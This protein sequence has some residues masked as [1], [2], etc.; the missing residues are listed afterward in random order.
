MPKFVRARPRYSVP[1]R[2]RE[3]NACGRFLMP[4]TVFGVTVKD[5]GIGGL[6][7]VSVR[8]LGA[9]HTTVSYDG[10]ALTDVQSGQ[11]DIGRFRWKMW[12]WFHSAAVK[13]ITSF[14]RPRLCVGIGVEHPDTLA[15]NFGITGKWMAKSRWKAVHSGLINP[16]SP[17]TGKF[18][19]RLS[20][21]QRW[22]GLLPTGISQVQLR[23]RGEKDKPSME[24]RRN[25]DVNNLRLEAALYAEFSDKS[26]GY[27]KLILPVG[28]RIAGRDHLLQL[29]QLFHAAHLGQHVF[30]AGSLPAQFRGNGKFRQTRNTT[31]D[32]CATLIPLFW[33]RMENWNIYVHV[34]NEI[35]GSVSTLFRAFEIFFS[36]SSDISGNTLDAAGSGFASPS[37]LSWSR[38]LPENMYPTGATPRV[39]FTLTLTSRRRQATPKISEN[40]P[41][42]VLSVNHLQPPICDFG[43]FIR[44]YSVLFN[45]QWFVPIHALVIRTWNREHPTV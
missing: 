13:A 31:A 16:L 38:C 45:F 24:T 8:S 12:I 22:V 4:W 15:L 35:Y 41:A 5:Y 19:K 2:W 42:S 20:V 26:R 36:A 23:F 14:N 17:S 34:Q 7:T 28:A 21:F 1:N 37:R 11:I 30:H 25:T 29:N 39:C 10:I 18:N 43:H 6:K 32:T 33:I 3:L 44:I 9:N 27:I 40:F